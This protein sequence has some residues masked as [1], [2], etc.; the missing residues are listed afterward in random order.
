MSLELYP[1]TRTF[2]RRKWI[3]VLLGFLFISTGLFAHTIELRAKVNGDGSVTFYARTYHD[4]SQLPSGGFIVDGVTYPFEGYMSASSLPAGTMLISDCSDYPKSPSDNYQYVT[5]SEF[6]TCGSHTFNCTSNA[7]ETPICNLSTSG[8][9]TGPSISGQPTFQNGS[10]CA[11]GTGTLSVTASGNDLTYQWQLDSGNGFVD[12]ANDGTYSGV[13]TSTLNIALVTNDM[14]GYTYRCVVTGLDNCNNSATAYSKNAVLY[15]T[16]NLTKNPQSVK[17]CGDYYTVFS[18]EATGYNI[19]YQWQVSTDSGASWTDIDGEVNTDYY[20]WNL[21]AANSGSQ[22]RVVVSGSCSTPATSEVATLTYHQAP[23]ISRQPVS[24]QLCEGNFANLSVAAAGDSLSYHWQ[25]ST[26][27]GDS[28][29]AIDGA[30]SSA[31]SFKPSVTNDYTLYRALITDSTGCSTNTDYVT[32]SVSPTTVLLTGAMDAIT[33]KRNSWMTIDSTI[34]VKETSTISGARI[35]I[36]GNFRNGDQL[37]TN[38]TIP[39]GISQSYDAEKGVLTLEGDISPEQLQAIFRSAQIDI[40]GADSIQR[41]VAFTLGSAIPAPNGH[42]YEFVPN[43]LTW[44]DAKSNAQSKQYYGLQGY[45]ATITS[46]SESDYILQKLTSDGWV[47]GTDAY[48][49]INAATGTNTYA[50]QNASESNWYWVTGPEAGQKISAGE[51]WRDYGAPVAEPG[52][53]TNWAGGEPNNY[54]DSE[55]YMQIYFGN[56]ARWNDLPNV[57]LPGYVIEYGGMASDPCMTLS[58]EKTILVDTKPEILAIADQS[59]CAR[60]EVSLTTTLRNVYFNEEGNVLTVTSSNPAIL[61]EGSMVFEDQT[62]STKKLSLTPQTSGTALVTVSITTPA[63]DTASTAFYLTALGPNKPVI[64]KQDKQLMTTTSGTSYTWFVGNN[65]AAFQNNSG[66]LMPALNGFY[67]VQVKDA[68]GCV[69]LKSDP[70]YYQSTVATVSPNPAI[71]TVTL[72][73]NNNEDVNNYLVKV[74]DSKGRMVREIAPNE[75]HQRIDLSNLANGIYYFW[76][77]PKGSQKNAKDQAIKIIK[78]GQ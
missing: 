25:T 50:D 73:F 51:Y 53:Y 75:N 16:I 2:V 65:L 12:L 15:P 42:F 19:G 11:G 77:V 5:V 41:R 9:L 32:I 60:D 63:G 40:S 13:N 61:P 52:M 23:Q 76:I 38:T 37:R 46:Q 7:P 47:G 45:L 49:E 71:S 34:E 58:F 39:D 31:Y 6:N 21:S 22:Y 8:N 3:Y 67:Q 27:Y 1:P 70:V 24:L 29:T 72:R 62:D 64:T 30:D 33:V 10:G 17:L 4:G 55:D 26:D 57:E 20:I 68:N 66:T 35:T 59:L 44:T 78:L 54:G 48:A 14:N 56:Q 43:T 74:Y 28:W 36:T 69:S 18:A